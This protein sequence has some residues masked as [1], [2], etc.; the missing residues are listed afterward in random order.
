MTYLVEKLVP[1]H[2]GV[3]F[4]SLGHHHPEICVP[5][6]NAL[7]VVIQALRR[8]TNGV[9]NV[10]RCPAKGAVRYS[11]TVRN[12]TPHAG[13]RAIP[14]QQQLRHTS[15]EPHNNSRRAQRTVASPWALGMLVSHLDDTVYTAATEHGSDA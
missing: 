11:F 5:L 12:G 2:A 1:K 10:A 4:E 8:G 13:S 14:V 7:V 9:R 6:Q 3:V 15:G